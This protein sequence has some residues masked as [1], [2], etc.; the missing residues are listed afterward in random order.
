MCSTWVL[1]CHQPKG[2]RFGLMRDRRKL[3][4]EPLHLPPEESRAQGSSGTDA[5][6]EAK[7]KLLFGDRDQESTTVNDVCAC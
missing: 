7:A 1:S 2:Q 3:H 5:R 4:I 6:L